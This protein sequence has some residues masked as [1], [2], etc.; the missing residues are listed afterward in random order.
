[1]KL[2]KGLGLGIG[3]FC[4]SF[5]QPVGAE[6][7]KLGTSSGGQIVKIDTDSV[8]RNGNSGSFWSGFT[9]YLD[10]E[11]IES[12]ANCRRGIWKVNG[13][14]RE[15][16]PQSYATRNM[17][18]L[19]CSIRNIVSDSRPMVVVFNPP[20]NI[21]FSPEGSIICTIDTVQVIPITLRSSRGWFYTEFCGGG[22]IHHSQIRPFD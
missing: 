5:P 6:L 19:V 14:D 16:Q 15:Y 21:R 9:Y 7:L 18:S 13:E 11:P 17:L 2:L 22:W 10:D 1:M 12:I 3:F 20:S 4:L 8:E